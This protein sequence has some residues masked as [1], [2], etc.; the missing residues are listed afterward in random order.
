[1][2]RSSKI[3]VW[4]GATLVILVAVLYL[5]LRFLAGGNYNGPSSLERTLWSA[6]T[7]RSEADV[8][9]DAE[10]PP[11]FTINVFADNLPNARVLHVTEAGDLL[12]STPRT[13]EIK[14]LQR[15]AD[16]D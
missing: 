11:G 6:L 15:D 1:M 5:A 9:A 16:G 12:L 4:L 14:L 13:G 8:A 10:L 2:S 7:G 3:L